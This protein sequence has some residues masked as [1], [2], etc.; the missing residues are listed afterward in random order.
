MAGFKPPWLTQ[1]I[2]QLR[3]TANP[4]GNGHNLATYVQLTIVSDPHGWAA[5]W[6]KAFL[7]ILNQY[8]TIGGLFLRLRPQFSFMVSDTEQ[9]EVRPDGSVLLSVNTSPTSRVRSAAVMARWLVVDTLARLLYLQVDPA[10]QKEYEAWYRDKG[11]V[12][13]DETTIMDEVAFLF[14]L[15][16]CGPDE[17]ILRLL[18]YR[19]DAFKERWMWISEV[20]IAP[21]L[22]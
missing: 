3:K 16:A 19:L 9:I 10:K 15:A 13:D 20:M 22:T 8:P 11:G 7:R 12:T 1:S 4:H 14:Y 21:H 18:W 5:E 17:E 6:G 2:E